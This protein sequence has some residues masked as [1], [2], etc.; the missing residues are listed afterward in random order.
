[1]VRVYIKSC[2]QRSYCHRL[3]YDSCPYYHLRKDVAK[4]PCLYY[5]HGDCHFD[6]ICHKWH[7][8]ID[9]VYSLLLGMYGNCLDYYHPYL[10]ITF[11]EII[12]IA[13]FNI[14]LK[15]IKYN[16]HYITR[17]EAKYLIGNDLYSIID[18]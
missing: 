16:Q 5:I 12:N 11:R 10:Y 18:I 17:T 3:F 7:P 9:I 1:M 6:N 2:P 15:T 8:P 13:L 14:W 4:V